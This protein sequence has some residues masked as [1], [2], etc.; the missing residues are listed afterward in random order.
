MRAAIP[1]LVAIL[2]AAGA[3]RAPEAAAQDISS[4]YRFIEERQEAGAFAGY[5]TAKTGRFGYGPSGGLWLGGRYG[6]ELAGPLSIEGVVG[7]VSGTRD[8]IS[9]GRP[10]GDRV[11]GE[12]DVL[13]TTI[14]GRLKLSVV[15]RR[16][17]RGL[18]PFLLAGGGVAFDVAEAPAAETQIE[19]DEVFEFGPSF[20]GTVGIGT[21]WFI[22][23]RFTLR[24]DAIFSLWKIT[25]P[26]GFADQ[27][28]GFG[29]VAE[30]EWVR[31]LSITGSL[32]F[33]W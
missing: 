23:E 16:A 33:R 4:P 9:P 29:P 11:V 2:W 18:S 13:L 21:R 28:F 22:T 17:W 1:A 14:D 5:L 10:E 24:T 12:A 7:L 32:L 20:F 8:I 27:Q 31:G 3:L 30:A 26:A 15:G 6:L 19:S 25:T